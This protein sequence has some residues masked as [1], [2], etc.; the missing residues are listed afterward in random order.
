MLLATDAFW[1]QSY[2]QIKKEIDCIDLGL[3]RAFIPRHPALL[4]RVLTSCCPAETC[5]P[6]SILCSLWSSQRSS[7]ALPCGVPC[8]ATGTTLH[9][10]GPSRNS[11]C[12]S[13]CR[14]VWLARFELAISSVRGK[15]G[16]QA[17]PQPASARRRSKQLRRAD[18]IVPRQHG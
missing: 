1:R 12:A 5:Q 14:N 16:G 18:H 6:K 3:L 9:G 2:L 4:R 17:P 7:G 8:G 15:Q 11:P 13:A 10:H